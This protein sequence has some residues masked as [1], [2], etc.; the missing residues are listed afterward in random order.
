[1]LYELNSYQPAWGDEIDLNG[2]H[3]IDWQARVGCSGSIRSNPCAS[4]LAITIRIQS[5]AG[6]SSS[7]HTKHKQKQS[8][9]EGLQG[10]RIVWKSNWFWNINVQNGRTNVKMVCVYSGRVSRV[11]QASNTVESSLTIPPA[12]TP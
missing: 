10:P 4:S 7:P 3:Q 6:V 5:C 1:M 9:A 11:E 12:R 8:T 2:E